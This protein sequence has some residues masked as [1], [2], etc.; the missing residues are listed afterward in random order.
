MSRDNA[1]A[2]KSTTGF[3]FETIMAGPYRAAFRRWYDATS[4][5]PPVPGPDR[6]QT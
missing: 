6:G 1:V 2:R 4:R 3:G 5:L